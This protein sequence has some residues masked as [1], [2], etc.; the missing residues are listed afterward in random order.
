MVRLS[1]SISRGS[2]FSVKR[3]GWPWECSS[4]DSAWVVSGVLVERGGLQPPERCVEFGEHRCR[5]PH[6]RLCYDDSRWLWD[7]YRVAF[8]S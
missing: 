8:P 1:V 5:K 3:T 4:C 7:R 2:P 6:M